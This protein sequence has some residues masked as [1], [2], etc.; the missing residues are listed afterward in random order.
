[1]MSNSNKEIVTVYGTDVSVNPDYYYNI[2]S[3]KASPTDPI[4]LTSIL[5]GPSLATLATYLAWESM[6]ACNPYTSPSSNIVQKSL[7]VVGI[8]QSSVLALIYGTLELEPIID[9]AHFTIDYL[10]QVATDSLV[11]LLG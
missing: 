7:V 5:F 11:E 4:A 1:M 10:A 3:I 2:E 9:S 6:L 8:T